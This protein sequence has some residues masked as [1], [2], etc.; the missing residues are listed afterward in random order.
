MKSKF[1][2]HYFKAKRRALAY[3]RALR[4]TK[5]LSSC[6]VEVQVQFPKRPERRD[7]GASNSKM[8]SV[9]DEK[10]WKVED[11]MDEGTRSLVR[12]PFG[13]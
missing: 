5:G 10:T 6:P 3:S 12:L 2:E 1:I 11:R 8:G 7:K 4:R 13:M 9:D